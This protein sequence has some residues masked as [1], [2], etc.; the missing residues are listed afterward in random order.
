VKR[1]IL[2]NRNERVLLM[3]GTTSGGSCSAFGLEVLSVMVASK[4]SVDQYEDFRAPLRRSRRLSPCHL[5]RIAAFLGKWRG[6]IQ[7]VPVGG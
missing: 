5:E 1:G 6:D 7:P 2:R 4:Q 3:S